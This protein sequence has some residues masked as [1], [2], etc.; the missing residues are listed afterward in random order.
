[1]HACRKLTLLLLKDAHIEDYV[2][3]RI[4][5]LYLMNAV[6]PDT[7][8][9]AMKSLDRGAAALGKSTGAAA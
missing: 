5:G 7:L 4:L 3:V 1:M 6:G 8:T 2:K 9:A